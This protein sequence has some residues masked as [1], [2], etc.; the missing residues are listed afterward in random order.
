MYHIV[1]RSILKRACDRLRSGP[2]S[3]LFK[4]DT[5]ITGDNGAGNNKGCSSSLPPASHL[6]SPCGL[7]AWLIYYDGWAM[8]R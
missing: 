3:A 2:T 8:T 6:Y 5:F 4:P 7:S 1:H